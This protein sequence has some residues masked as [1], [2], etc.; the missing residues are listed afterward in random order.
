MP[1]DITVEF[2]DSLPANDQ[3]AVDLSALEAL[4]TRVLAEESVPDET[5]LT[6]LFAD[7]AFLQ[8]LNREHRDIDEPTDVLSFPAHE[9][10][11]DDEA[12]Y[13]GAFPGNFPETM[14]E[15]RY[16]GDIAVSV[17]TALR[18]AAAANLK[19]SEEL[20][21]LVLHGLL[22]ILG[23][24]HE[25]PEEDALMRAREEAELGP[26]IHARQAHDLH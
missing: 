12:A 4:V 11:E 20:A 5:V 24:D 1:Y 18:Q 10:D 3:S 26:G 6:V 9:E 19:P 23:Y 8:T 2:H 13:A 21:H 22:H 15:P 7:D 17:P 16:L 14:E 25:T